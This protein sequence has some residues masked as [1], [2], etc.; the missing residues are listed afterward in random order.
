V[1][2][3]ILIPFRGDNGP[4]SRLFGWVCERWTR[5]FP[6]AELVIGD[7]SRPGLFN[8]AEARN[9]AFKASTG[10]LLVIADA[11][12]I[13]RVSQVQTALTLVDA[14]V[15]WVLPYDIYYN[16][17]E[18]YTEALLEDEP[19]S[20]LIE[21]FEW[22]HKIESWAGVLVLPREAFDAVDG[23]DERFVSWGGEDNAFQHSLDVVWGQHQRISGFVCHLWHPRGDADFSNPDWPKNQQLLN[24]YRSAST[25]EGIQRV[26]SS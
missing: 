10:D 16:L 5:T 18:L 14:G 4:R 21:P 8:R 25:P 23:Y 3:S 12:T 7:S 11:D 22:D 24:R 9:R 6:E 26:R 2:V 20:V 15:P 17:T 19:D 1:N 13:I